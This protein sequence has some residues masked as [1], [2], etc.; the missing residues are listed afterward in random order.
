MQRNRHRQNGMSMIELMVAMVISLILLIGVGQIFIGT[1]R[2]YLMN[3]G[4]SRI[5]EDGR[6]AIDFLQRTVRMADYMGCVRGVTP[7]NY[8]NGADGTLAYDF[9]TGIS[10][11]EASG[12]APN[13][14]LTMAASNFAVSSTATDWSPNLI[15][16]ILG[17]AVPGSDIL[18]TKNIS[19]D[20]IGLVS[21]YQNPNAG[22]F[23]DADNDLEDVEEILVVTDCTQASVFQ[24]TNVQNAGG[25]PGVNDASKER[26]VHSGG[27]ASPGNV[28]PQLNETYGPGAEISRAEVHAFYIGIGASGEPGLFHSR[29]VADNGSGS[30]GMAAQELVSNVENMQV[31]YGRDTDGDRA[32]DVYVPASTLGATEANWEEVLSVRISLLVRSAEEVDDVTETDTFNLLGTTVDPINDQRLRHIFTTTVSIRNR[33]P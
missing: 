25:E 24:A 20:G 12:T 4:L 33:A 30:P 2:A 19:P 18:I 29:L 15:A 7:A 22:F 10:G 21:P 26:V 27:N 6:F 3:E 1:K 11:Y 14:T 5:Q 28:S 16:P 9:D 17:A 13:S 32:V 8:L 31:L 23:V